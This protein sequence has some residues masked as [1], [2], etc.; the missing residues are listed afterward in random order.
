MLFL[1]NPDGTLTFVAYDDDSGPGFEASLSLVGLAA[2]EYVLAVGQFAL[3]ESE[4]RAGVASSG[5]T[6]T[7][8]VTLTELGGLTFLIHDGDDRATDTDTAEDTPITFL[9]EDLAADPNGRDLTVVAV[10]D[11]TGGTAI[12]DANGDVVF[13]PTA[14]FVGRFSFN[15]DVTNGAGFFTG[16]QTG[17]INAV[18]DPPVAQPDLFTITEAGAIVA[19]NLFADNGIEHHLGRP[20]GGRRRFVYRSYRFVRGAVCHAVRGDRAVPG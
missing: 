8:N 15:Y 18:D 9:A 19:G 17:L 7:Y 12:I 6:S 20:M 5:G 3:T 14:D 13:T 16:V 4:A 1:R 11:V 10:R 2:G